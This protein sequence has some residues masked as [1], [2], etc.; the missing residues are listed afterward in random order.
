MEFFNSFPFVFFTKLLRKIVKLFMLFSY[1]CYSILAKHN[2]IFYDVIIINISNQTQIFHSK[3]ILYLFN[4][5]FTGSGHTL[6]GNNFEHIFIMLILF[7]LVIPV[8]VVLKGMFYSKEPFCIIWLFF[9]ISLKC[10]CKVEYHC[11]L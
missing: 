5:K 9:L 7:A 3:Y 8:S 1:F 4:R 11:C 2:S 10:W 6:N